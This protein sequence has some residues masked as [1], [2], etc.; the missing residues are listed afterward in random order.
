MTLTDTIDTQMQEFAR[1]TG[2]NTARLAERTPPPVDALVLRLGAINAE[3]IRQTGLLTVTSIDAVRDLVTV[4]WSGASD[5]V[6]TTGTAADRSTRLLRDTGRQVLGD[7]RQARSTITNRV[8]S[9]ADGLGRSLKLVT[10]R[11]DDVGDRVADAAGD[12]TDRVIKAADSGVAESAKTGSRRPSGA[13]ANW[14]REE[15]YE[16]AQE[17]DIEGRSSMTK[18]ELVTALRSA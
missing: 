9:A 7:V 16:R 5:I 2:A 4:A 13:Y 6:G 18:K 15:L 8:T 10:D 11:A 12:A 1:V 3:A 14:S 17:L